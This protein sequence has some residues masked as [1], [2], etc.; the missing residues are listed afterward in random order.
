MLPWTLLYSEITTLCLLRV[1]YRST[2]V[3]VSFSLSLPLSPILHLPL[4]APLFFVHLPLFHLYI[5][6]LYL[7]LPHS[8]ASLPT[9]T[10]LAYFLF[11]FPPSLPFHP[12]TSC[13][14]YHISPPPPFSH[15]QTD[16]PTHSRW[17]SLPTLLWS[18]T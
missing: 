8:S 12:S 11:L 17:P 6:C 3:S 1:G 10:Q 16:K 14:S 9:N 18:T 7:P 15:T 4:S 5:L 2:L 13:M